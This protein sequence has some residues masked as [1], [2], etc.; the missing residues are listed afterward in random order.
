MAWREGGGDLA[1]ADTSSW[2]LTD[3]VGVRAFV[4]SLQRSLVQDLP[5][6]LP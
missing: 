4:T 5:E 2:E 3:Y 1:P 6:D